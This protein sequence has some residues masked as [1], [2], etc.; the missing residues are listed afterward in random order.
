MTQKELEKRG[1]YWQWVLGL[2]GWEIS[3]KLA[4]VRDAPESTCLG[5]AEIQPDFLSASIYITREDQRAIDVLDDH[6]IIHELL[7]VVLGDWS[8]STEEQRINQ[9][10]RAFTRL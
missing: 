3:F 8:D 6:V 7:H 9:L 2:D 1:A 4:D 10:A 5:W